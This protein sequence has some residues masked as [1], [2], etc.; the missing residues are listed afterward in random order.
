MIEEKKATVGRIIS[1]LTGNLIGG[2]IAA[3]HEEGEITI[4]FAGMHR[5]GVGLSLDDILAVED[6]TY[7]GGLLNEP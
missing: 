7:E 4:L 6:G 3:V 5:R 2:K 1:N